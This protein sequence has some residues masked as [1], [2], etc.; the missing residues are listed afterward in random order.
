MSSNAVE[1]DNV[2]LH[3]PKQRNA[4]KMLVNLFRR[5]R[6]RFTA[7]KQVNLTVKKEKF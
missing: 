2:T 5:K 6:E 1:I 4:L 7:L 3:F